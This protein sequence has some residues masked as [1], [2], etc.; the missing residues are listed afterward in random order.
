MAKLQQQML[1]ALLGFVL[2]ALVFHAIGAVA[3]GFGFFAA[4]AFLAFANLGCQ[5]FGV[6]EKSFVI[7]VTFTVMA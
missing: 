6:F 4:C 2:A 7:D 3:L 5:L 1:V